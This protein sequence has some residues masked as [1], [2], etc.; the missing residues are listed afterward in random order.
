MPGINL[1]VAGLP[2]GAN[3]SGFSGNVI[4]DESDGATL[5]RE[6][7][8]GEWGT[9]DSYSVRLAVPLALGT[10]VYVT[11][12]AARSP[13]EEQDDAG[14]GDSVLVSTDETFVRDVVENGIATTV[15]N[16][17]V[18]LV[19]DST[20]WNQA[21][22]VFV[23][24]ANDSQEEGKR[25][26]AVSHSV[27]AVVTHAAAAP[28][29]D[30]AATVAAY[31]GIK[32]KNVLVTVI[33]N[34]RAGILLT[35]VR[36]DAYDNGTLVL[37][38]PA[39]Y[40]ITDSYTIEL[41]KAPTAPVTI[42]LN[43]DHRQLQLSQ[44]SVTFDASNWDQPVTIDIIARD[45]TLREDQKLS[46]ITHTVSS[47]TDAAYFAAGASTVSETLAV[48]V[49]DNDVPGVLVQQS[50]GSTLVTAGS[51][52]VSDTYAVRLNS[53]PTGTV[54]IT[55]LSD[56]TTTA[57]TLSFDASNWWIPQIVTVAAVDIID[58]NSP[59]LHPGT[60]QFAVQPH[61]LSDIKGP[62]EIEG[63]T[64]GAVHPLIAG[65]VLPGET[66][67]AVLPIAV[68]PPEGQSID[69]LNVFDDSSQEDKQ[70]VLTGTQLTGFGLSAG[71]HFDQAALGENADF[72]AGITYGKDDKSNIE[73]FNLL[74]GSGDDSP[75]HRQHLANDGGA[76][77]ADHDPRRRQ[78]GGSGVGGRRLYR[79]DRRRQH[80]RDRRRRT[81]LAP[82]DLRRHL[83]RRLL[84]R[85]PSL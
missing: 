64:G 44:D 75:Q 46:L 10:T 27:Q 52:P 49:A 41:T 23:A 61:L 16:R 17:A 24:A 56:G 20:N 14:Q 59:L 33:D 29:A 26:V 54:T 4:I 30:Q 31:D 66:N 1:N 37:E 32:V 77:G 5:V 70:G 47:S 6:T 51:S 74:M 78:P 43:Y 76:R 69:I 57:S 25:V 38:G 72:A 68:Q 18:V 81:H 62:L 80:H 35:E 9:L 12:S 84:V 22:T 45:D 79:H 73:V 65:V 48:T 63:G 83:P 19:F 71:L 36:K 53:A 7:A 28:A 58:P 3:G 21:Q 55:P 39:P 67:A 85:R 60:K 34:D 82:G 8:A 11:V 13:Q 2:G 15:R 42:Q 40:G 50:N